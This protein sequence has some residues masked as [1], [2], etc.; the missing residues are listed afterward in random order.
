MPG[1][2]V[3]ARP[4]PQYCEE[5]DRRA[6]QIE[7]MAAAR[8]WQRAGAFASCVRQCSALDLGRHEEAPCHVNDPQI[9]SRVMRKRR[10]C[11]G[12]C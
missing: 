3:P 7:A 10:S 2:I 12:A 4:A 6:E 1:H 11:C 8:P 5:S 9:L